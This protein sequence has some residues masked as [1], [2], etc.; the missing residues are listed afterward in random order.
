MRKVERTIFIAVDGTEFAYESDCKKYEE[1][2]FEIKPIMDRIPNSNLGSGQYKQYDT[3]FLLQIKRDLWKL[4]IK[5]FGD[6]YPVWKTWN[7]DDVHPMSIVGR[8][9]D[10]NGG[11][12]SRC[13]RKLENFNFELGREYQQ[14][15]F[16]LHPEEA[17][18]KIS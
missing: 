18:E 11:L 1:A 17:M 6:S 4:V 15:Y 10:D 3:S 16:A 12:I 7:A 14:P 9:L 2:Y 13:W 5:Q 8:I